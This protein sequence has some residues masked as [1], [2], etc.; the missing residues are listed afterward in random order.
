MKHLWKNYAAYK[1]SEAT[2][3]TLYR[4]R[5]YSTVERQSEMKEIRG[6]ELEQSAKIASMATNEREGKLT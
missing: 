4:I 6:S 5:Y 3:A 2:L 1:S